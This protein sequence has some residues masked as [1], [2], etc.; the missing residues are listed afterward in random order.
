MGR[1]ESNKINFCTKLSDF[2]FK[3]KFQNGFVKLV[4]KLEG[5][6]WSQMNGFRE[7]LPKSKALLVVSL[8]QNVPS[9][10]EFGV[11]MCQIIRYL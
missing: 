5:S 7:F 4:D 1:F 10:I 11:N 6:G 3:L 9:K 2:V 8:R